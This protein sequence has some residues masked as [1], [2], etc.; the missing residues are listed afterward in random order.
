MSGWRLSRDAAP[1]PA[2]PQEPIA[3]EAREARSAPRG[4]PLAPRAEMKLRLGRGLEGTAG[5][6]HGH[7]P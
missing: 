7:G 3:R 6:R 2:P 1:A 4:R 5:H